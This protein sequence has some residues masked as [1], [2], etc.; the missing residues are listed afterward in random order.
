M[1]KKNLSRRKFLRNT[2]L[3]VLGAGVITTNTFGSEAKFSLNPKIKEYREFGR[4]G[5]KV[6]DISCGFSR[7][8]NILRAMLDSGMNLLET[9]EV[10]S[11]GNHERQIGRVL[12][13]YNRKELFI[14]SKIHSRG[15]EFSSKAEV[16]SRVNN[17]L[18]R[19]DIEYLDG[20]MIHAAQSSE[21]VLNKHFHSAMKQLKKEGKVR[22]L[23][24]SCHGSSYFDNPEESME[25]VL[26]AAIDD[27]RFDFVELIYNFFEPEM[28]ARIL[29]KCKENNIGTMIMKSSP[30]YLYESYRTILEQTKEAGEDVPQRVQNYLDK[31]G[32][33][34]E[35]A[36]KFFSQYGIS[37]QGEIRKAALQFVLANDAV[38]TVPA[39]V[40]RIDDLDFH[41]EVSG[42]K[43]NKADNLKLAEFKDIAG[44]LNCR[45]GCD[46]CESSC[47]HNLP[48]NTILRY[49]YYYM[50][51]R[52]EKYA[53]QLYSGLPGKRPDICLNCEGHCENACPNGVMAKRLL[54]MAHENLNL[55]SPS[56]A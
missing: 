50:A 30:V 17:S 55:G 14:T 28:G 33:Q 18:E 49:N 36:D 56:F 32:A 52:D 34:A 23:G 6:S 25:E 35:K 24:V 38:S 1:E 45:I 26:G 3:G 8:E 47:P 22:F 10:Y 9:S 20:Y 37:G 16:I 27:G 7:E 41:I 13:D 54:S 15:G 21:A 53:M 4:T 11:N 46:K 5:F 48:V 12:K 40:H 42:T 19:L 51:K 31:Y 29:S 44:F 43:L 2:S 39:G